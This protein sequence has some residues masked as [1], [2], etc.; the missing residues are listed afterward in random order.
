MEKDSKCFHKGKYKSAGMISF[1]IKEVV[2][3]I[4]TLY[5]TECGETETKISKTILKEK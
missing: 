1:Q 3:I 5:C 2:Y 4:T